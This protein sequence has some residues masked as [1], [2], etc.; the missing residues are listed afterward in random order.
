MALQNINGLHRDFVAGIS[1][2]WAR[3][4]SNHRSRTD[5]ARCSRF[6][7]AAWTCLL[8]TQGKISES[9]KIDVFATGEGVSY[10]VD[11]GTSTALLMDF[12]GQ[13]GAQVDFLIP[14]RVLDGYGLSPA[15]VERAHDLG[16]KLII[17][18][19]NGISAFAGI[20]T[21]H[22]HSIQVI[23]TDHHLPA[24]RIPEAEAIVNPNHPDC[25]FPWKSTCGVGVAFYLAAAIRKT[26]V[27]MDYV[28]ARDMDMAQ[29]L[30]LVALGTVADVVPLE[31]NNRILILGGLKRI[32]RGLARPGI[33]ALMQVSGIVPAQIQADDFG[34]RLGPDQCR[35]QAR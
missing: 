8:V 5:L 9:G 29:F 35:W 34:F 19:D 15:L 1:N 10:R 22:K 13:L 12:L 4:V 23:V 32:R 14:D 6:R 20:E 27:A 30:D 21:A 2:D 17:T 7:I 11:G 26:L 33:A 18:V 24:E 28:S 16:A 31:R 3:L 25:R